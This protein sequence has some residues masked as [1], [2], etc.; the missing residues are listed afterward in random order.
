MHKTSIEIVKLKADIDRKNELLKDALVWL[1]S[2]EWG[3]P[4]DVMVRIEKELGLVEDLDK[5]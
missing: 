2:C 3:I 4:L 5:N 1:T